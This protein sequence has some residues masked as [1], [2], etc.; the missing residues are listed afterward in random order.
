M[1]VK[2]TDVKTNKDTV[3]D[4]VVSHVTLHRKSLPCETHKTNISYQ[5]WRMSCAR[6]CEGDRDFHPSQCLCLEQ[7]WASSH[8][9]TR[10]I[11]EASSSP[12][13]VQTHSWTLYSKRRWH[14][15]ENIGDCHGHPAFAVH[16]NITCGHTILNIQLWKKNISESKSSKKT[17]T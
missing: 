5:W 16:S 14:H 11:T 2:T 7:T 9:V 4:T 17:V 6:V 13:W 15:R 1:H 10:F 12:R 3:K 8:V